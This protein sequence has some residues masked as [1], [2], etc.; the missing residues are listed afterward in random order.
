[1]NGPDLVSE[2]LELHRK[3]K[4]GSLTLAESERWVMLKGQLSRTEAGRPAPKPVQAT[5]AEK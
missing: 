3:H 2:F 4:Q 5:F 1:M